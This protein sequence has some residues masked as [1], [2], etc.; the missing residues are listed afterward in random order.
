MEY[1]LSLES[2]EMV[3]HTVTRMNLED[4][5]PSENKLVIKRQMLYDFTYLRYL[6]W[7]NSSKRSRILI[8]RGWRKEK[9]GTCLLGMKFQ[10]CK[11]H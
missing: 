6:E 4:I 11:I 3:T 1:Y 2:K 8:T 9:S 5:M 10:F 7:S